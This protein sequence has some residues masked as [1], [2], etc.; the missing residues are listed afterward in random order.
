MNAGRDRVPGRSEGGGDR[1]LPHVLPGDP[2]GAG[3]APVRVQGTVSVFTSR[4]APLPPGPVNLSFL[5][6]VDAMIPSWI[7]K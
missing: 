3:L 1:P 2:G 7:N 4:A 5:R 6:G